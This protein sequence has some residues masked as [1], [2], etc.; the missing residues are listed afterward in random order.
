MFLS[1]L[2]SFFSPPYSGL[3]SIAY[4]LFFFYIPV[5]FGW[6]M[7]CIKILMILVLYGFQ[8]LGLQVRRRWSL[9]QFDPCHFFT[10]IRLNF[11][12]LCCPECNESGFLLWSLELIHVYRRES[13]CWNIVFLT[14]RSFPTQE[15][16]LVRVNHQGH[17]ALCGDTHQF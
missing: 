11:H 17:P 15:V 13:C 2:I 5:E 1:C 7:R 9:P 16:L 3:S 10:F 12:L 14:T 8:S 4:N 6:Y